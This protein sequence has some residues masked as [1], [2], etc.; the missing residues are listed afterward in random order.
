[1]EQPQYNLFDRERSRT[2]T[3]RSTTN[4]PRLTTWSPLASGLL[5]GKYL[6]ASRG[7]PCRAPRIRMAQGEVTAWTPTA[8][9]EAGDRR[10]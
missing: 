10:R 8:A 6:T 3:R 9:A 4:R 1:M 2:S 5:T 7:L